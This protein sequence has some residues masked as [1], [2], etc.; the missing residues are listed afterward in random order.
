[1]N[2]LKFDK[3]NKIR[4][5]EIVSFFKKYSIEIRPVWHPNHLQKPYKNC[6]KF[7]IDNALGLVNKIIFQVLI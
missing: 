2:I 4:M 3:F 1:M 6:Q 7:K 5:N